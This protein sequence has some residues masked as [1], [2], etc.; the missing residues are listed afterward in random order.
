MNTLTIP[1]NPYKP[2]RH[3]PP[4][5]EQLTINLGASKVYDF[6]LR[7]FLG[8]RDNLWD[9]INP[10]WQALRRG[11]HITA[12][13]VPQMSAKL[14][15][16]FAAMGL[17]ASVN[18]LLTL[19][20]FPNIAKSFIKNLE[21]KDIEGVVTNCF[22][23]LMTPLDILDSTMTFANSLASL[24]IIPVI[25]I[26]S[27]ISLPVSLV[28]LG[29]GTLKGTYDAFRLGM[30]LSRLPEKVHENSLQEF[31][32]SIGIRLKE[33]RN[34]RKILKLTRRTDQIT[35]K[36]MRDLQNCSNADSANRKLKN[37]RNYLFKKLTIGCIGNFS[38]LGLGTILFATYLFPVSAVALSTSILIKNVLTLGKTI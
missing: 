16:V 24:N 25:S 4:E 17:T 15:R 35:V 3:Q 7:T 27:M 19:S 12:H 6:A 10:S 29:Y 32:Q 28:L 23:L 21:L 11:I 33:E 31:H 38:T 26:F 37:L 2:Q 30:E 13:V 14:L 8:F 20:K 34:N 5:S 9:F 18:A 1:S 22:S 36:M